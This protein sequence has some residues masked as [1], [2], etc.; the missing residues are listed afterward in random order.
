M[1]V[2][3]TKRFLGTADRGRF[4]LSYLHF[5]SAY[6]SHEYVE[7]QDV[8]DENRVKIPGQ[9]ALVYNFL[10][11]TDGETQAAFLGD[12]DGDVYKV[13]VISTNAKLNQ[14]FFSANLTI[15]VLG[16]LIIEAFKDKMS[17]DQEREIRQAVQNGDAKTLLEKGLALQ[18]KFGS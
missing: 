4:I 2:N 3:R 16:N 5:G 10:W 14:P 7:T 15:A 1:A 12:S 8:V 9:F 13:Q 11:E 17:P 18:Q 6:R